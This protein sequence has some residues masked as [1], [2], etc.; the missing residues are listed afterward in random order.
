M[1]YFEADDG[2]ICL[3]FDYLGRALAGSTD[4]PD[5]D[6]DGVRATDEEVDYILDSLRAVFPGLPIALGQVVHV[7]SGIRPLPA[8][9]AA[10]PSLISR[11]HSAPVAEPGPGRPFAVVSLVGGKWTTF[12]GFAEEVA[13]MV[14]AQLGKARRLSTREEAIGGGR[15]YPK[16]EARAAW[17]A[18]VTEA[19]GLASPRIEELLAR[20][21]TTAGAIAAHRGP[22]TDADRLPDSSNYSLAEIDWIAREEGVTHLADLVMRR[23]A[24]AVTGSLTA[25]DL[26]AVAQVAARAL[27][28]DEARRRAEVEAVRA[29]LGH[30][31]RMRIDRVD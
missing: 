10:N 12:R 31:H 11:D 21:G 6:P 30:A 7:Y 15:G 18:K 26:A 1:I 14:L 3:V 27:G 17:V 9:D 4:I 25:R 22:W 13:D 5:R 23:T 20:Y 16:Q 24:L 29:R 28:W 8:S 19:T 2:R